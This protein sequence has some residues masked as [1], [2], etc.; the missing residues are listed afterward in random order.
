MTQSDVE[1]LT[2]IL[3]IGFIT[4]VLMTMSLVKESNIIKEF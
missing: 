3:N 4:N 2:V 1:K